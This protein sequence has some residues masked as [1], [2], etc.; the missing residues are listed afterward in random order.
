MRSRGWSWRRAAGVWFTAVVFFGVVSTN[1][2]N[3]W[4]ESY[5]LAQHGVPT[6]A[7]VTAFIPQDHAGCAYSYLV[8]GR[9]YGGTMQACSDHHG[10]GGLLPIRYLPDVLSLST[11]TLDGQWWWPA[12]LLLVLLPLAA[13]LVAGA[14]GGSI[15][16]SRQRQP[17]RV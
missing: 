3:N 9:S 14:R 7:T 5:R 2:G 6:T 16:R 12:V 13:G 4:V 1:S 11:T 8:N 10:V 17:E 15:T